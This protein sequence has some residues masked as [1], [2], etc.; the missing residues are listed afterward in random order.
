MNRTDKEA[1]AFG[2]LLLTILL[3]GTAV[4]VVKEHWRNTS[5]AELGGIVVDLKCGKFSVIEGW[6]P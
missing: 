2:L 4:T 6:K 3:V 5:C 1:L